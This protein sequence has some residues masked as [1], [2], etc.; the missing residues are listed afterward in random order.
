MSEENLEEIIQEDFEFSP[1]D[2]NQFYRR[3]DGK[4]FSEEGFSPYD[5]NQVGGFKYGRK[6]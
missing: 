6:K 4:D 2:L 3:E 5:L 1:Y